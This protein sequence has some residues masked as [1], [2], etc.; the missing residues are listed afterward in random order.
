MN[1]WWLNRQTFG[2]YVLFP[3]DDPRAKEHAPLL[4][5]QELKGQL[6]LAITPSHA[7]QRIAA[8]RGV[9]TIHGNKRAALDR[10]ARR[11]GKNHPYLRRMVVTS[12]HVPTV[13]REL[14]ISGI[15]ESLIFPELS[16][17]C[18]EIKTGFFGD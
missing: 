12:A 9:F 1:P 15:S 11:S 3:A 17:L 7:S 10:L 14:A 16:G 5:G 13:R 6:P 8:Q 4:P 18:R 2:E